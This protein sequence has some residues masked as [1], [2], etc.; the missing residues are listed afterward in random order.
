MKTAEPGK[1]LTP[2]GV[3]ATIFWE[4]NFNATFRA[5]FLVYWLGLYAAPETKAL[6]LFWNE[7]DPWGMWDFRWGDQQWWPRPLAVFGTGNV[8]KEIY[9]YDDINTD[10]EKYVVHKLWPR[11][12]TIKSTNYFNY[13]GSTRAQRDALYEVSAK[14][15]S[16][17][18]PFR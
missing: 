16:K 12:G 4:S 8:S 11:F 3:D 13:S 7:W 9:V 10:N 18:R 6:A 2:G 15:Q 1:R 14:K 17:W 5:H